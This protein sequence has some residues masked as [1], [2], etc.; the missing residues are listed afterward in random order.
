MHEKKYFNKDVENC[1]HQA[2]GENNIVIKMIAVGSDHVHLDEVIPFNM[3]PCT[4]IGLLKSRSAYSIFRLHD[5][6]NNYIERQQFDKLH[7][8]IE[9]AKEEFRQT[10]LRNFL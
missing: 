1:I 10:S 3:N 8:S 2:A 7:D 4:A 6:V 9:L 5:V